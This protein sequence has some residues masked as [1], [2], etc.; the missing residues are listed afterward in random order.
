LFTFIID[1]KKKDEMMEE[2]GKEKRK[3]TCMS[4]SLYSSATTM[5]SITGTDLILTNSKSI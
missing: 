3:Q 2:K 1:L 4:V 5:P